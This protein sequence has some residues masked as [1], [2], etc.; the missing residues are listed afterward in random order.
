MQIL[1]REY[2]TGDAK[3]LAAI[4]FNTVHKV[5]IEDYTQEEVDAW[6]PPNSLESEK[7]FEKTKPLIA[8]VDSEIVGYAEFLTDGHIDEFYCHHNWIGKGVGS[9]LLEEIF[10]R[11][12]NLGL[13]KLV[14]DAS[15]TAIPFF[16]KHGFQEIERQVVERRDVALTNVR[17]ERSV[18]LG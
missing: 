7:R 10:K 13:S 6:A 8:L 16:K 14:V 18:D 15:L 1:I 9:T 2:R 12:K 17:M 4:F 11:A 3:S 5:N